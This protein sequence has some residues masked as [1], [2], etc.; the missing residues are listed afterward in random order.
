MGIVN[1]ISVGGNIYE[2]NSVNTPPGYGNNSITN[3][4]S[5][6]GAL[7]WRWSACT[8][9]VDGD[10]TIF[11]F[12]LP[13]SDGD[14][15]VVDFSSIVEGED[16]ISCKAGYSWNFIT[17]V[18][19]I[20][21]TTLTI[22]VPTADIPT[23]GQPDISTSWDPTVHTL[24][25]TGEEGYF[26]V[27]NKPGIGYYPVGYGAL[28]VGYDNKANELGAF[29]VG[30]DNI[31][32]GRYS[33][34]LGRNNKVAFASFASGKDNEVYGYYSGAVGHSNKIL[35]DFSAALGSGNT[36]SKKRSVALGQSNELKSDKSFAIGTSNKV[37]G[38]NSLAVGQNNEVYITK[39]FA[40]GN[41]NKVYG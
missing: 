4:L 1:Q 26:W 37:T 35:G 9:Q 34:A 36:I 8:K 11:T 16:I 3:G 24:S 15:T 30:Y 27:I 14:F 31:A 5:T 41:S 7:G 38:E 33:A 25:D 12:T 18:A 23:A 10:D 21:D 29:A 6:A 19:I 13:S 22:V 40:I 32:D 17:D 28:G 39:G 2:I 20:T